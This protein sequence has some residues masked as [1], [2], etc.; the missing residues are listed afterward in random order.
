VAIAL[1]LG[2]ALYG[3]VSTPAL[4][5]WIVAVVL[6]SAMRLLLQRA[7]RRADRSREAGRWGERFRAGAAAA[8]LTWGLAAPLLFPA[9]AEGRLVLAFV[10]AGVAAG[11]L[12]TLAALP[13]AYGA[14]LLLVVLPLGAMLFAQA[15]VNYF[16]MGVTSLLF[17]ALLFATGRRTGEAFA[18]SL[19]LRFENEELARDLTTKQQRLEAT[20]AERQALVERLN[21]QAGTD[22]LTGAMNRL[23]FD[24]ILAMEM[25]RSGRYGEPLS[26]VMLDVDYFKKVNDTWGHLAGDDLLV[27]LTVF[28]NGRIRDTEVLARWGGEEFVVLAPN[29]GVDEAR[30]V[31]ERLRQQI[32]SGDFGEVGPVT[33]SFGVTQFRP[34]EGAEAFL[35]RADGALYRAKAGGRNRVESA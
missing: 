33:C 29:T 35:E 7:Y 9:A 11:G 27:M 18:E 30:R 28:V 31:A 26:L 3:Q 4:V 20:L 5:A 8:G 22:K 13:G 17:V 16:V 15:S 34:G 23:R 21:T 1:L 6:V 24:E 19:R 25:K 32:A 12:S 10:L 14:F 2:W